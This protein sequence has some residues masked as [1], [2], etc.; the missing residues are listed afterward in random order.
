VSS[1]RGRR[2]WARTRSKRDDT[3]H[4]HSGVGF[5]TGKGGVYLLSTVSMGH[6]RSCFHV[7]PG[8]Q[9]S[10]SLHARSTCPGRLPTRCM[11]SIHRAMGALS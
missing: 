8:L 3:W 10:Y 5:L 4:E 1:R 6:M 7:R 2:W 9:K 11:T